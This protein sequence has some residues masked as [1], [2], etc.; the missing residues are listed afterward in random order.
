MDSQG[1][2]IAK[3]YLD[4]AEFEA[5]GTSN[6][7]ETLAREVAASFPVLQF[8]CRLPTEKK[9]PNLLFA[10]LQYLACLPPS[11]ALTETVLDW[12]DDLEE[13]MRKRSTQTNEP[14]RCAALM[15]IL[16][17]I[18]KP[19]AIVE[20]GASA[21]LC[22]LPDRYGYTYTTETGSVTIPAPEERTPVF[23]CAAD[24]YVPLPDRHP[25]IVW[26]RGLDI[27][28]LN[29]SSKNDP[30]W[31]R[32]LVWPEH[33]KRRQRLDKALTIAAGM[34]ELRVDAGDL[35][36]GLEGLLTDVPAGA[37]PYRFGDNW[38]QFSRMS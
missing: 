7:Y 36:D 14:G 15:P 29:A 20:V 16:A 1:E 3:S 2:R 5:R 4:F 26:R 17:A 30:A 24:G 27:N 38:V 32:A 22:L 25:E 13:V 35:R 12:A 18:G 28:P 21:G 10:A 6:V 9:Q 33:K 11:G 19:L 23:Q 37:V 8:L 34:P 31:L